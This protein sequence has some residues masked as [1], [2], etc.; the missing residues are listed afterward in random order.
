ML[1]GDRSKFLFRSCEF[2]YRTIENGTIENVIFGNTI[3]NARVFSSN[4][5]NV[6]DQ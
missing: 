6:I 2:G 1:C 4:V 5:A 3:E